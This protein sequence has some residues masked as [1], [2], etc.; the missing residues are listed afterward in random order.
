MQLQLIN[1][2]ALLYWWFGLSHMLL[3]EGLTCTGVSCSSVCGLCGHLKGD[4]MK[5][6]CTIVVQVVSGS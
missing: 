3:Y 1:L 4:I 2:L 5:M 6:D